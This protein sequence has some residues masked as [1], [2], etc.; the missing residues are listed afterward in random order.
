MD[1]K[2]QQAIVIDALED[3]KAHEIK[4]LNVRGLSNVT[5]LMVIATGTSTRQVKS[6]AS[7]VLEKAKANGMLP[8]GVEGDD[9]GE[10]VLVDLGDIVVHVMQREIRDF[11]QLERLWSTPP[12]GEQAEVEEIA[13]PE[14]AARQKIRAR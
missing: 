6:I 13:V 11:Y 12:A 4:I 2:K 3:M 14:K 7:N 10:W 5:D 9:T 1:I 8:I